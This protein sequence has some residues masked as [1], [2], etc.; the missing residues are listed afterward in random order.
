[1]RGI[2]CAN[3]TVHH[4][5]NLPPFGESVRRPNGI[6]NWD[7]QQWFHANPRL[8]AV[9]LCIRRG[10]HKMVLSF[11]DEGGP[12]LLRFVSQLEY[13]NQVRL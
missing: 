6:P 2:N 10:D 13:A 1:M 11:V 4:P 12:S 5:H 7:P 8:M 3:S 9:A